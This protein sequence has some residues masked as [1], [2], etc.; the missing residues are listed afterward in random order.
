MLENLLHWLGLGLCHQL[1]ERSFFGGGVQVPVCARDTGI[2]V[3]FTVA[4][5][6]LAFLERSRRSAEIPPARVVAV[7]LA[8]IALMAVDG[9]TSYLGIRETNNALRL[10]T[11]LAAGFAIGGLTVPLLNSQ[12]WSNPGRGRAL[13]GGRDAT[14][15]LLAIPATWGVVWWLLPKTGVAY[16]LLVAV[17]IVV[18]F[19]AVN[20]VIACLIPAFE[21][22]AHR[23]R[24]AW[25][26]M[27]IALALT[28]VELWLS[29][30]L[31]VVLV[32]AT[33]VVQ[34]VSSL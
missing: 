2:Y 1:P 20:L 21:R 18:T 25:G 31:R 5:M 16:P 15:F 30:V 22:R 24:D 11:G 17:C 14:L 12:L 32:G 27:L 33:A 29:A 8:G 3:G 23:L 10:A 7:L 6:I 4:L 26:P 28:A 13:E 9:L 19:S 34:Q